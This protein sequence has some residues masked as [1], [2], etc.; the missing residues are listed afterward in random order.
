MEFQ[1]FLKFDEVK[2]E[3]LSVVFR[4]Y[5]DFKSQ[6]RDFVLLF[7]I[8]EFFETYF[9]DAQVFS[10]ILGATLTKRK[11]NSQGNVLMAGIPHKSLNMAIQKL[12][13]NNYKIAVVNQTGEKD[14]NGKFT[15]KITRIYTKGTVFET[16]FL[17]SKENNYLASIYE[18]ENELELCYTDIS[19]GDVYITKG[20]IDEIKNELARINP[21]ELLISKE[22]SIMPE[23]YSIYK[24]ELLDK[25]FLSPSNLANSPS[26]NLIFNY[27]N[28]ILDKYKIEFGEI[29]FYNVKNLMSIDFFTRKNLEI[30]KNILNN[31][32]YGS[33]IWALDKCKTPMGK[34]KLAS[35]ITSPLFNKKKIEQRQNA[36][37]I[38]LENKDKLLELSELIA[39]TGDAL[40][41]TSKISNSLI[42]E[43]DFLILKECL[44]NINQINKILKNLKIE[45]FD[46][47][48][49]NS[50]ALI[51]FA[52]TLDK[53]FE[54]NT[55][56]NCIKKG[57]NAELD[58][59]F[60]QNEK[61]KN[62]IINYE[63]EL[64][65][66]TKLNSLKILEKRGSFLIELP[67]NKQAPQGADFRLVKKTK[68]IQ[69]YTTDKLIELEEKLS[70]TN[71][72]I[73]TLKENIISKLTNH[74]KE[75]NNDIRS[76]AKKIALL[77]C[78]ISFAEI[79]REYNLTKPTITNS[80][81]KIEKGS[82]ITLE[83]IIKNYE[84]LDF[85]F[86]FSNLILLTGK[87]GSGKSTLLK[88]IAI[89]VILAQSGLFVP[90]K[91]IEMPLFD[92]LFAVLNI[93][94]D[95]I[96]KKSTHQM[97]IKQVAYFANNMTEKSL[98][99][100]DE[101][102]KN[103]AYKD[104]ISI[105]F[106]VIKYLIQTKNPKTIITTHFLNI[107]NLLEPYRD[108]IDFIEILN[109]NNK[110][111]TIRGLSSN[112]CGIETLK[113]ENIPDEI[114]NFSYE[115]YRL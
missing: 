104:G 75:L 82:H 86:D 28:Y 33:L 68:T 39:T 52:E 76:Y 15:R 23:I 44:I 77:D 112:S 16:L 46:E 26:F 50:H 108:K 35:I 24:F 89:T 59:L 9:D 3:E 109:E 87:N 91:N 1:N 101:I 66:K 115:A 5:Y 80:T 54:I 74:A 27:S 98:I 114:I 31:S 70:S 43:D 53:T 81:F 11:F 83:A 99:L 65:E 13:K 8:G 105:L 57:A 96:S 93:S 64:K 61:I 56:G 21:S 88:Q 107:Y 69:K 55:N 78:L 42:N 2:K 110:R 102:G 100:L 40:R 58:L 36:I 103:T 19:T 14:E 92:K 111:K 41:L 7:R 4:Q 38:L 72:K 29:K 95:F 90:A 106:G 97:Q 85:N 30:T 62:K 113:E 67:I 84:K 51:D 45:L 25:S 47:F 32:E 34:R 71:Y 6:Y 79:S 73:E 18:L 48:K 49:F 17:N 60:D 20:N 10:N 37:Q 22:N 12:L 94:D 63:T